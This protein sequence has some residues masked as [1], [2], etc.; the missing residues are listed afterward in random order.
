MQ[1]LPKLPKLHDN[2]LKFSA[3]SLEGVL[4]FSMP[5]NHV[6]LIYTASVTEAAAANP[7][8][9][10]TFLPMEQE[11]SSIPSNKLPKNLVDSFS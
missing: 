2:H 8:G 11:L 3:S 4:F 7:S 6:N 1:I 5:P 9:N 10:K